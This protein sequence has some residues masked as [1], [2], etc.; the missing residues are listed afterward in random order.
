LTLA[1]YR[2]DWEAL[3][4]SGKCND[5]KVRRDAIEDVITGSWQAVMEVIYEVL[6]EESEGDEEVIREAV[7]GPFTD[8][9]DLLESLADGQDEA[10]VKWMVDEGI[11]EVA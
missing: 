8:L 9:H 11:A 3:W 7:E 10:L 6:C 4:F 5:D 1:V 2:S